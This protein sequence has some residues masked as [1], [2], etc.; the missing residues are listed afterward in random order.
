MTAARRV[1][2]INLRE[3]G[4]RV[5]KKLD[6]AVEKHD[7]LPRDSHP[8]FV[9]PPAPYSCE[10]GLLVMTSCLPRESGNQYLLRL[11]PAARVT[12]QSIHHRRLSPHNWEFSTSV[13]TPEAARW[14]QMNC[15][16]EGEKK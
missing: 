7:D 13:L 11:D 5:G 15:G 9:R 16:K 1:V 2:G 12:G 3:I 4:E 6:I 10:D 8:L 14:C